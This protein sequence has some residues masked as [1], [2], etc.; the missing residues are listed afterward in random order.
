MPELPESNFIFPK[1]VKG[2]LWREEGELLYE[3]AQRNVAWGVVV[4]LGSFQGRSTICLA[5]GSRDAGGGRVYAG[6]SFVGDLYVGKRVGLLRQLERNLGRYGLSDWVEAVQG[7][8][9]E[10]A[11][12]WDRPIRM[13]FIDGSHAYE[14]VMA[15]FEA[16]E[17]FLV[18][19]SILAFHDSLVWSGVTKCVREVIQTGQFGDIRTISSKGSVTYMTRVSDGIPSGEIENYLV[20]FDRLVGCRWLDRLWLR[21]LDMLKS[22]A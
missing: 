22:H 15:D 16:W 17:K 18:D 3:L 7:D 1:D 21:F 10:V 13:L 14:D 9:S 4:E 5:Q 20:E 6:D 2:W 8:F 19:G 11:G 12:G